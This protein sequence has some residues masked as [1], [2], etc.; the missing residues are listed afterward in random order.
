MKIHF[1]FLFLTTILLFFSC[2]SDP[3]KT[4]NKADTK[5]TLPAKENFPKGVIIEKVI[6]LSDPS[7][8]YSLY[9]PSTYITSKV[10]PVIYIFDAHGTGNF[11]VSMYKDLAEKYGYIL[12]GSN[13]SK[14]GISW[15][16]SKVIANNLFSDSHQRLSVNTDRIYLLGFSGGARVANALC[17]TNGGISGV[18]CCGAAAPAINNKDPRSNYTFLGICGN[19]DFNYIE[20]RKYDMVGLAGKGVKHAFIEFDGKHEWPAMEV[21]NDAFLWTELNA[22]RNK[23]APAN[24]SLVL[25]ISGSMLKEI[26]ELQKKK[27]TFEVY[28]L[29]RKGINFL[30]GLTPLTEYY[31]IYNSLKANAEVDKRLKKEDVIWKK[32]DELKG[33]YQRAIQTKNKDW[34]KQDIASLNKKIKTGDPDEALMYQR[35]LAHLSIIAYMQTTSMLQNNNFVAA[36]MFDDIYIIV[37]RTNSEA[38][39]LQAQLYAIE[40]NQKE[41]INS[42]NEAVKNGFNDIGRLQNDAAYTDFA[43]SDEFKNIIKK[44][45]QADSE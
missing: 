22:I 40:G 1:P 29:V 23:K 13:N 34:W 28:N 24:D 19:K 33:Y 8:S 44:V 38:Y 45:S 17:L 2:A 9:L 15:E 20:M 7:Q 26:H 43:S 16:E 10:Y 11:P 14:N 18:I 37:D 5:D 31:D 36:R 25:A 42:L 32:E 27:Q 12:I 30:D 6:N 4:G 35:V 39:Y 21:M 3:G 41:M